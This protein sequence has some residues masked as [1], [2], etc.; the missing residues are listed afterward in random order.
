MMKQAMECALPIRDKGLQL[1]RELKLST[2][3]SFYKYTAFW[4]RGEKVIS[5]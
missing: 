2:P 3:S 5:K 1:I 4:C